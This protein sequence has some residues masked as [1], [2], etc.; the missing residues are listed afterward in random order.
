MDVSNF[1]SSVLSTTWF[2]K[3]QQMVAYGM[4]LKGLMEG[5]FAYFDESKKEPIR[6]FGISP[7]GLKLMMYDEDREESD[8]KPESMFDNFEEGTILILPLKGVMFK[9]DTWWSWGT[10]TISSLLREAADHENILA[11]ILD[12]DSGGGSVDSISPMID[13]ITYA[14][15]KMP[16]IAL[17]DTA[18][19]AAYYSIAPSDLIIASNNISAEFGSIGVM[20]NFWDIAPYWEKMGFKQHTIYAEESDFKNLPFENALKGDYK[21]MKEEV[22]SPLARKFQEDVRQYRSGKVNITVEGILNGKMFYANDAIKYGLADEIGNL[23]YAI[24]R[25]NELAAKQ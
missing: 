24:K 23:E 25:A 20:V 10:D 2:F 21:L 9:E 15:T 17:A 11:V 16:V 3:P 4:F 7:S 18:A 19:S 5:T 13:T 22:L 1:L 14:K 12:T 8:T 6:A